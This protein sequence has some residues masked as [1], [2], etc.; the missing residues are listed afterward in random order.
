MV[1]E[2]DRVF[3][4]LGLDEEKE[5]YYYSSLV[6]SNSNSVCLTIESD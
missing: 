1:K 2:N 3:I 5:N 4:G 6:N